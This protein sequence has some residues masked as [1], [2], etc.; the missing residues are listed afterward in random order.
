M[1]GS[2]KASYQQGGEHGK[3]LTAMKMKRSIFLT[4]SQCTRE[5]REDATLFSRSASKTNMAVFSQK[6]RTHEFP[7]TPDETPTPGSVLSLKPS[8]LMKVKDSKDSAAFRRHK[9]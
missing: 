6:I 5:K 4:F 8:I 1:M 9:N 2:L 7:V 3:R